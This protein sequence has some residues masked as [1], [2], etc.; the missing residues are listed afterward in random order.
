M[1][2][3]WASFYTSREFYAGDDPGAAPVIVDVEFEIHFRNGEFES[4]NF[5]CGSKAIVEDSELL[6]DLEYHGV[7]HSRNIP[8]LPIEVLGRA[9]TKPLRRMRKGDL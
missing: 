8:P 4:A 9:T 6:R 1:R 2:D 7:A 5:A 3:K